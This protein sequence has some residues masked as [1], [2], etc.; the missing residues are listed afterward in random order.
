MKAHEVDCLKHFSNSSKTVAKYT[1]SEHREIG[2]LFPILELA[3]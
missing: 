3:L 2:V 1:E